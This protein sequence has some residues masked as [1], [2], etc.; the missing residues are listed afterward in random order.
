MNMETEFNL[1]QYLSRNIEKLVKN[2]IKATLTN[3]K[4]SVFM[5]KYILSVKESARIRTKS[6][7][8]GEH[9][10]PFLIASITN[11]CNLHCAGC[12]ARAN[13]S[14]T[15]KKN[16]T[17]LS[18][19]EWLKI[20][21]EAKDM[22]ISFI[23]LAGGEPLLRYDVIKKATTIPEILFPVFTNG[24]MINGEYLSLFDKNRNIL[25]ILSIEGTEKITDDRRGEGVYISLLNVMDRL[26]LSNIFYGVSIT[27]TKNNLEEV[28]G[29][30]FIQSL[31]DRGCKIFFYVEYV[32]VSND[33]A[34]LAPEDKE[35][36]YLKNVI[37]EYR[38]QDDHTLFISFPGD[39]K[40]SG[41][42][43]AAGRGFFHINYKGGAEMCPF[44]PYSDINVKDTSLKDALKSK[45]FSKLKDNN[46]LNQDHIGGCVLFEQ[47][48]LVESLINT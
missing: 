35:R 6:E 13:K 11:K 48:E 45:L 15:D 30:S 3:P 19:K 4:Q 24:T 38:I 28:T 20:F 17:F 5:A 37:N 18:D 29:K 10:P 12:Y 32:P 1:E 9:I 46:I 43:L 34:D 36:E 27:V 22:G 33:T 40:A 7:E 25:P 31:K 42:C 44:S 16:D 23:L 39:E 21:E 47:R 2:A 41:G 8:S 14:C 26:N